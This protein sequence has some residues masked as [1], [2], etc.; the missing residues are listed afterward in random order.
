MKLMGFSPMGC[1]TSPPRSCFVS[2]SPSFDWP[3]RGEPPSRAD[4]DRKA[5]HLR[6]RSVYPIET[7]RETPCRVSL[8]LTFDYETC[9]QH[10][11]R[12]YGDDGC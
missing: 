10:G 7:R 5:G 2:W 12:P 3:T 4:G 9:I 6:L 1:V 8:G 11:S